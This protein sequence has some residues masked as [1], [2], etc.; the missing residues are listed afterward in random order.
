MLRASDADR[1]AVVERLRSAAVEGRLETEELDERLAAALRAR[2]YGEL[3]GL[4]MDLPDPAPRRRA[5]PQIVPALQSVL[6]VALVM[7]VTIAVIAAVITIV[8][9]AAAWWALWVLFWFFACGRGGC[10]MRRFGAAP[11]RRMRGVQRTRP[12]GLH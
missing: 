1:E 11:G 8:A 12:V 7:L 6:A 9:M 5:Q 10:S 2:T 4:L 3:D